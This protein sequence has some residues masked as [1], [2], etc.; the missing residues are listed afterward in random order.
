MRVSNKMMADTVT[1][2]L[3]R[4]ARQ[5]A[6]SQTIITTGKKINKASDNPIGMGKVLEYRNTISSM[7]QYKRN[8]E[9][10]QLRIELT[11]SVLGTVESLLTQAKEIAIDTSVENRAIWSSETESI[12]N[13]V[14]ELA[15]TKLNGHTIFSGHQ[16]DGPAFNA[17]G[18]YQGDSGQKTYMVGDGLTASLE[19]DG[20]QIFQGTVDIF[21]VLSDLKTALDA[22]D[23]AA[24][25]AQQGLLD[26]AITQ[27]QA[28]RTRNAAVSV[29]IKAT[30]TQLNGLQGTVKDLLSSTE[31]AN[32]EEA[33]IDF[34][35]QE[36]AYEASLAV[37]A[38]IMQKS[39][40]DFL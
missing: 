30:A 39:L 16:T 38:Q 26:N 29:R 13:Q 36:T 7:D 33:I 20:E 18:V 34:K 5:M 2:N 3:A 21:D 17:A 10:A 6:K 8:I 15:N 1:A 28:V 27:I 19:A 32:L 14:L 31:D 9:N 12:R 4:Q 25:R 23:T 22:N 40:V 35:A 37:S 11:E 24:I